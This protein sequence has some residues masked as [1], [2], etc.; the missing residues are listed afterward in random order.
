MWKLRAQIHLHMLLIVSFEV[1]ILALVKVD[2]DRQCFA[3][4]QLPGSSPLLTTI[5]QQ[6]SCLFILHFNA[7]IIDS[8][9]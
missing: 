5:V 1:S 6:P 7:E 3:V 9:E 8:A 2:H 4:T